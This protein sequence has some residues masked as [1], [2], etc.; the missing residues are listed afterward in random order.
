MF[1]TEFY[2]LVL[3]SQKAFVLSVNHTAAPRAS[4]AEGVR[5]LLVGLH[6][7]ILTNHQV[8]I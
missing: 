8:T 2:L 7:S 3:G 1:L 4:C 5:L 6:T